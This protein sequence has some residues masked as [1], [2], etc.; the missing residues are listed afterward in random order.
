MIISFYELTF[1]LTHGVSI[2]HPTS[3]VFDRDRSNR[4][5]VKSASVRLKISEF[6]D[7]IFAV[8]WNTNSD[9]HS[10][11]KIFIIYSM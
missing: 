9:R 4:I 1:G 3:S 8:G 6:S 11:V 10:S 5:G 7:W 2:Y